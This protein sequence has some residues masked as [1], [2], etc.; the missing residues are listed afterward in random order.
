VTTPRAIIGDSIRRGKQ[1]GLMTASPEIVGDSGVISPIRKTEKV[2]ELVAREIL[3]DIAQRKLPPGT[4]LAP[5]SEM[6]TKFQVSRASLRE[7]LRVLEFLGLI[8]MKAGAKGGPVVM[9][10]QSSDFAR[11]ATM[12]FHVSGAT[13]GELFEARLSLETEMAAYAARTQDPLMMRELQN[14]LKHAAEIDASDDDSTHSSAARSFHEIIIGLSGNRILDILSRSISDIYVERVRHIQ[15]PP[16]TRRE[17]HAAHEAI[18]LAIMKGDEEA[19]GSLMR[20]HMRE[21]LQRSVLANIPELLEEVID[22]R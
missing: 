8:R 4:M 14:N 10:I 13:I 19:A 7:A 16:S 17:I 2:S 21:Y 1:P 11:M 5:E 15:Y 9:G 22:W 18:A 20:A 6:L 3:R 12:Y